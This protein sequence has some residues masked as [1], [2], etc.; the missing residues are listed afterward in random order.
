VVTIDAKENLFLQNEAVNNVASLGPLVKTRLP[1]FKNKIYLRAA[2]TVSWQIVSTVM[3]SLNQ[4]GI[5]DI[6]VV[7]RPEESRPQ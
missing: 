7:T 1:D 6:V 5:R 4:S 2:G 3:D